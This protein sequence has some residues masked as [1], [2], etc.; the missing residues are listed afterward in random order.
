MENRLRNFPLTVFRWPKPPTPIQIV[1][2]VRPRSTETSMILSSHD[3]V[4]TSTNGRPA[5]PRLRPDARRVPAKPSRG[6]PKPLNRANAAP[7]RLVRTE[8]RQNHGR[9]E[10]WCPCPSRHSFTSLVGPQQGPGLEEH[11]ES[12]SPEMTIWRDFQPQIL[13][14]IQVRIS[15]NTQSSDSSAASVTCRSQIL[16]PFDHRGEVSTFP[17]RAHPR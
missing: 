1:A 7:R 2:P 4:T 6:S 11:G 10:S 12:G 17:K 5:C 16:T 14:H 9:T 15:R 13:R 3:S 8:Q